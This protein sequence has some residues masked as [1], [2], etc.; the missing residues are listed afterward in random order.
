[1]RFKEFLLRERVGAVEDRPDNSEYKEFKSIVDE[2]VNM[3]YAKAKTIKPFIKT[4]TKKKILLKNIKISLDASRNRTLLHF[5]PKIFSNKDSEIHFN[6]KC[7]GTMD[8]DDIPRL[9]VKYSFM[10]NADMAKRLKGLLGDREGRFYKNEEDYMVTYNIDIITNSSDVTASDDRTLYDIFSNEERSQ[11]HENTL[12]EELYH[13]C[14]EVIG[15]LSN[16]NHKEYKSRRGFRYK[17]HPVEIGPALHESIRM[18]D[19]SKKRII[20]IEKLKRRIRYGAGDDLRETLL[21]IIDKFLWEFKHILDEKDMEL[22]QF[23]YNTQIEIVKMVYN[24]YMEPTI[25]ELILELEEYAEEHKDDYLD[26]DYFDAQSDQKDL[27]FIQR[28][29]F[30]DI[31]NMG[32]PIKFVY[33][34]RDGFKYY[35]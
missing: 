23:P 4:G 8:E 2:F 29:S 16:M 21:S 20:N 26:D 33:G 25:S 22:K 35:Y 3:F 18:L 24:E 19:R 7:F 13:Y 15:L 14:Q 27:D 9:I 34:L 10:G 31:L 28:L 6:I 32:E 17:S 11:D 1:M 12:R 5:Y 30:D